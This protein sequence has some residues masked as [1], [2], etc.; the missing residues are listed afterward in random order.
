LPHA[1]VKSLLKHFLLAACRRDCLL[2]FSEFFWWQ[3]LLKRC[4]SFAADDRIFVF[5]SLNENASGVD[6]AHDA[7]SSDCCPPLIPVVFVLSHF[8]ELGNN[9]RIA[10]F[11]Q[12]L[13]IGKARFAFLLLVE[14]FFELFVA[15]RVADAGE[16]SD[17]M[18]FEVERVFV[19]KFD[20]IDKGAVTRISPRILIA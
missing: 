10:E 7:E 11:S 6:D 4:Q 19:E 3:Y 14:T 16:G 17:D 5:E 12:C 1:F 18:Y 15:A 20:E 2:G 9:G 13:D 8:N